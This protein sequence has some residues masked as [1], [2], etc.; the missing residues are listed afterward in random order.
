MSLRLLGLAL[1]V[2]VL[3]FGCAASDGGADS[4]DDAEDGEVETAAIST[5]FSSADVTPSGFKY[6]FQNWDH[7]GA[8][9]DNPVSIIFVSEKPNLVARVYDQVAT[10]GLTHGGSKM[11]LSGI[12]GSRPGVNATDPWSSN[13]AGRKGAF[14]CWGKCDP[15]AD[16]HLRTYGADGKDGTQVYQG[17]F[18]AGAYYLVATTHF[19]VN[20]NTPKA[21]FGYQD[22]ARTLLIAKM[23]D[24]KK[25]HVLQSVDVKNACDE[26]MD[27]KHLCKHDG[28]AVVVSID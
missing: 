7:D 6:R 3:G 28:K 8:H 26:R 27:A 18:G 10:V 4:D 15:H 12:G 21:D 24:A 9:V 19:D 17:E 16:I 22:Q 2:G 13:S 25:W 11:N 1:T 20:E 23:V 14:G 5:K